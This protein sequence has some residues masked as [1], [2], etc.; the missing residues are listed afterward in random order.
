[1]QSGPYSVYPFLEENIQCMVFH[2]IS[3]TV[4]ENCLLVIANTYVRRNANNNEINYKN[5]LSDPVCQGIV[6]FSVHLNNNCFI[7]S[8]PLAMYR[9]KVGRAV[10]TNCV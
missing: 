3:L 9:N 4:G 5:K 2:L 10:K 6:L 1:M 8:C 7:F